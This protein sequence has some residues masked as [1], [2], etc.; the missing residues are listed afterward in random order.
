MQNNQ[1][2]LLYFAYGEHMNENEMKRLF[3][4]ARMV[5]YAKLQGYTL[6]FVGRDGMARAG[7]QAQP[8]GYLPGCV[9]SLPSHEA[10][11][12]D[13]LA[14]EAIYTRRE[15]Q[16]VLIE[17]I[18]LPVL[19]YPSIPGQRHGRPGFITYDL[20]CEAYENA[21]IGSDEIK[22]LAMQCAPKKMSL[23]AFSS[24]R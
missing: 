17:G 24:T 15:I 21:C 11:A 3:P 12:L 7:T 6:C 16:S 14:G 10:E 8:D 18:A 9:W 4:N 13:H 23:S 5:G 19:F 1:S 22:Y 2:N 20:L